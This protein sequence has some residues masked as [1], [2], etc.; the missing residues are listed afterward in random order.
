VADFEGKCE[1][2]DS[3]GVVWWMKH[4]VR[5]EVGWNEGGFQLVG[6]EMVMNIGIE[7]LGC[8]FCFVA[9]RGT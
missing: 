6:G 4:C 7:K 5:G 1:R 2:A 8:L 3:D 9:G